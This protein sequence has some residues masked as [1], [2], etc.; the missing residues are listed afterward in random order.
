[1][2]GD[3][4]TIYFRFGSGRSDARW[5]TNELGKLASRMEAW[6]PWVL[7]A[8]GAGKSDMRLGTIDKLRLAIM[9]IEF[10]SFNLVT[11]SVGGSH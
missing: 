5:R 9:P 4:S 2:A 7:R 6:L 10:G 11:K 1:M 3:D 8:K